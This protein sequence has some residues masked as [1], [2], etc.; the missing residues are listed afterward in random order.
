MED[1]DGGG[2]R[3]DVFKQIPVQ[4]NLAVQFEIAK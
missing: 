2:P 4:I 3:A 1:E